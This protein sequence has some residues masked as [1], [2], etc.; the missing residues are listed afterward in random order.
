MKVNLYSIYDSIAEV[1][2]K[3]FG[4]TTN[5]S[6]ER[7]YKQALGDN[8]NARDYLLFHVGEWDDNK[9]TGKFFAVPKRIADNYSNQTIE[10]TDNEIGNEA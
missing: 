5:G 4:E 2:N 6:A 10:E 8:P 3:P 1:F 9:G 7:A